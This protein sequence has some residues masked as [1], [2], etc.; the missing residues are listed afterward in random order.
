MFAP[1]NL[2][3][4]LL[5]VGPV[6]AEDKSPAET[7]AQAKPGETAVLNGALG[8]IGLPSL[9]GAEDKELSTSERARRNQ[10]PNTGARFIRNPDGSYGRQSS[11]PLKV[12]GSQIGDRLLQQALSAGSGAFTSWAEGWLGGYGKAR[13]SFSVNLEGYLSGSGDFLLPLYDSEATTFFT[14]L[15]LRTMSG[16]RVIG[17]L[18]LGQRFFFGPDAALGY[19]LFADQD[20]SR[21]HTRGGAG[22]EAWYDWLRFA[23]NYYRPLSGWKDSRD[24]D[25]FFVEERPAEGWD[26]R[27]TGYLPFYRNL[28]V[29]GALEKWRGDQVGAFG[30]DDRLNKNPKVWTAGLEWTPVPVLS[31]SADQRYSGGHNETQIGLTFNYNFGLP[32]ADQLSPDTVAEMRTVP[33]SRH[34]FVERQYD[35]I[36]EYQAKEG[37][38][39]I[40]YQGSG[41]GGIYLFRV[42]DYFG[43]PAVG[44]AVTVALSGGALVALSGVANGVFTTD[45][46]GVI[47]VEVTPNGQSSTT[48]TL[49]AGKTTRSFPLSPLSP[50]APASR[51]LI[52][53]ATN[54]PAFVAGGAN[55]YQSTASVAVVEY[56]DDLGN[57][58]TIPGGASVTW[59]VKSVTNPS[60]VWWRRGATALNGL[61]WGGTADGGSCWGVAAV[62][63]ATCSGPFGDGHGVEG[64]LPTAAALELTDVIGSRS[65]ILEA[66]VTIGGITYT[67][68]ETVSFGA[69]P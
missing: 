38:Y 23:A 6:W 51:R 17:N 28:A 63:G 25:P 26:A 13:L 11:S 65:V 54:G 7:P 32:W 46:Q 31:V 36:L 12:N 69:G 56:I 68:E 35:L 2:L 10:P 37:A 39:N 66:S 50:N 55:G 3:L 29:K 59:A 27:L 44:R 60:A 61:T 52:F 24:Y 53:A 30:R 47:R 49:T 5:M 21:S 22:L 62:D 18:G 1:V 15:G 48:A 43:N 9:S 67:G 40:T 20:F 58:Q 8:F 34:D 57:T 42:T 64:A 41:G 45:A 16:D 33:G 19:N 4:L 14:Q